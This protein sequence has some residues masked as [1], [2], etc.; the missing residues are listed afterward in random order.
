MKP[1]DYD[2]KQIPQWVQKLYRQKRLRW[3]LASNTLYLI[4]SAGELTAVKLADKKILAQ[5]TTGGLEVYSQL[6]TAKSV[7]ELM[8]LTDQIAKRE[9]EHAPA[10]LKYFEGVAQ[11]MSSAD[12]Q[13]LVAEFGLHGYYERIN[14]LD[15]IPAYQL[16]AATQQGEADGQFVFLHRLAYGHIIISF[17]GAK[18]NDQGSDSNFFFR[19]HAII[20]YLDPTVPNP[21]PVTL[22]PVAALGELYDPEEPYFVLQIAPGDEGLQTATAYEVNDQTVTEQFN[23]PGALLELPPQYNYYIGRFGRFGL[24]E[25]DPAWSSVCHFFGSVVLLL[26]ADPSGDDANRFAIQDE[27]KQDPIESEAIKWANELKC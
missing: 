15:Q 17:A 21:L 5:T 27:R 9:L 20:N 11:S 4:N 8:K 22:A 24:E 3:D 16:M 19:D 14:S 18:Q 6:P 25:P 26:F 12:Q 1:Y 7:S 10:T 23:L 13:E 2:L